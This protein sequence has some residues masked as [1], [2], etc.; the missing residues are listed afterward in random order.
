MKIKVRKSGPYMDVQILANNVRVDL[1]L[2]D[3][4]ERKELAE[5]LIAAAEKLLEG[6]KDETT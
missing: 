3:D 5:E 2:F 6:I 4:K 1:G